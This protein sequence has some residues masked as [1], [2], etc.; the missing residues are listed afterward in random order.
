MGSLAGITGGRRVLLAVAAPKEAAAVLA[1]FSMQP[2]VRE[3]TL[4]PLN[5]RF[6]LVVTGVGKAAAAG[7]VARVIDPA[8]HGLVLSV[9]IAGSIGRA[10]GIGSVVLATR[11]ELA[12][13][14]VQS[15]DGYRPLSSSG[16]G[17][18][19]PDKASGIDVPPSVIAVLQ[20]LAD[21]LGPVATVSLCSG[22][23]TAAEAL[24][25]RAFAAEAMEGAAV[26]LVAVRLGVSFGELRVVSNNTGER[27]RQ[28]WDMAVAFASLTAVLGRLAAL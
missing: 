6:D 20:P 1:A 3:W 18:F 26:A 16:F 2:P 4:I 9:G 28:R 15:S 11:C 5:E 10:A 14:G 21:V 27:S 17:P 19:P 22:T 8:R 23:D 7:A 13:D 24:E 25:Q 12:D